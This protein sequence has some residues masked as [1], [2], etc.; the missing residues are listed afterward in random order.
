MDILYEESVDDLLTAKIKPGWSWVMGFSLSLCFLFF[1]A[2]KKSF[3]TLFDLIL[4]KLNKALNHKS[5]RLSCFFP[6]LCSQSNAAAH[7]CTYEMTCSYTHECARM[8]TC[9]H[10]ALVHFACYSALSRSS[11]HLPALAVVQLFN[12][13]I[14]VIEKK[15]TCAGCHSVSNGPAVD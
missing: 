1:K 7:V 6:G 11:G 15:I 13:F 9:N 2:E 5:Q 12:P 14:Y 8:R 3:Q 10:D 4:S